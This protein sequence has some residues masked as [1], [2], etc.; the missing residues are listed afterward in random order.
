ML[1]I[2]KLNEASHVYTV[3]DRRVPG[4]TELL[5]SLYDWSG[6]P[7]AVLEFA[8]ER[9][10]AIHKAC[11]LHDLGTL[12]EDSVDDVVAPY[13]KAWIKFVDETG[14]EASVIETSLYHTIG[15]AG[16][17]DRGGVFNRFAGRPRA[18][19]DIK[20]VSKISPVTGVQLA[21]YK[22]LL[23]ANGFEPEQRYAVQL[24]PNGNYRLHHFTAPEDDACFMAQ[25][26]TYNWKDKHGIKS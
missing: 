12:D 6:I 8:R 22:R 21:A 25:L 26:A 2:V 23:T 17:P 16:T 7:N 3:G 10:S 1:P 4:V 13:L 9:G 19:V 20:G 18:V 5:S 15:Y 24:L 11:E 14:F